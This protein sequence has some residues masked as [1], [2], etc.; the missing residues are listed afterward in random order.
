[1]VIVTVLLRSMS[2][3]ES[4]VTD[5]EIDSPI[6]QPRRHGA[7]AFLNGILTPPPGTSHGELYAVKMCVIAVKDPSREAAIW[8][9]RDWLVW[10]DCEAANR[11][12]PALQ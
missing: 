4:R 9:R 12:A 5:G 7:V 2:K 1:M 11:R 10:C 8:S 3:P 6:S